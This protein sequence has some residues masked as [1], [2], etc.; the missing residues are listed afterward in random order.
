KVHYLINN[1]KN[2]LAIPNIEE[3]RDFAV[4]VRKSGMSIKQCAQG[5]RILQLLKI[6]GIGDDNEDIKYDD[7][8]THEISCFIET[9]YKN[10]KSLGIQPTIVPLWI[11]DLLDCLHPT[12]SNGKNGDQQQTP[13]ETH[14][15]KNSSSIHWTNETFS[16]SQTKHQDPSSHPEIKIPFFSQVSN[17][18]AQKKIECSKI[19]K[20]RNELKIEIDG[21]ELQIE[22]TR[23]SLNQITQD[24]KFVMSCIDWFSKLKKELWVSYG[25]AIEDDIQSFGQIVN[26]FKNH[27]F[28]SSRIIKEYLQA[29]SLKMEIKTN[30]DKVQT[31]QN[32]VDALN[33]S[34]LTLQSQVKMHRQ[35]LYAFSE[36]EAMKFG[37]N[38]LQQLWLTILE[39][40]EANAIPS[41]QAVSKFIKDVEEQYN[42][43]LGFEKKVNEKRN[44]LNQLN[45]EVNK[46]RLI[47]QATPFLGTAL[48]S[49]FKNGVGEQDIIGI[50]LLAQEYKN[51]IVSLDVVYENKENKQDKGTKT[52][53]REIWRL[54]TDELK[55]YGGIKIA[56][57]K[58]TEKLDM[59]KQEISDS[60]KQKQE[61]FAYCKLA[62]CLTN[63]IDNKISHL[64]G[65]IEHY[66]DKDMY[67]KISTV[68]PTLL[69]M[70]IFITDNKSNNKRPDEEKK[71][72]DK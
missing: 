30:E 70:L 16:D 57:R 27:G 7:D 51:N 54:L 47:L 69:P 31:L 40:A 3:V 20:Y 60:E 42:S 46:N 68:H 59:I 33:N 36:L 41:E 5:F 39:I 38:E 23:D 21:L 9:V 45:S 29:L 25:I 24:E 67:S 8:I 43:K 63:A 15:K 1:W 66:F 71:E 44:E 35:T 17:T 65:L 2:N 37:M 19:E 53:E 18:I 62:I 48:H 4:T 56:I 26:D 14:P 50:N 72:E 22:Q 13:M 34:V 49:L 52:D 12:T 64:R 61:A 11:K 6:I 10:C 58:Q 28:D 32:Q 55:R